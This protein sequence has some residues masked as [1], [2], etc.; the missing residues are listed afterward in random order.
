[1][2]DADVDDVEGEVIQDEETGIESAV[3]SLG[4]IIIIII[5]ITFFNLKGEGSKRE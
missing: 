4:I 3:V 1:M 2:V 5:I